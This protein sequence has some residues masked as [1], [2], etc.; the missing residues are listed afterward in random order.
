MSAS[1]FRV[2]NGA[3]VSY[4]GENVNVVIPEEG[5]EKILYF[6]NG[7]RAKITALK[8]VSTITASHFAIASPM[9]KATER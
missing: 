5:M 1:D 4:R 8:Y 7:K 3:L 9:Q 6:T 2:E